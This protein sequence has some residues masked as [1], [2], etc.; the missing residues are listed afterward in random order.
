[1][2]ALEKSNT[3]M[4]CI[5]LESKLLQSKIML[6]TEE[7]NAETVTSYQTQLFY[8]RS[9]YKPEETRV[10]PIEIY[11]NS[12]GGM[13]YSTLGLYDF[14][15]KMIKEGYVIKTVNMG[16]AASGASILLMAGSP[17][18]RFSFKH[19]TTMVHQPSS[20]TYGTVTDMEI[21]CKEYLRIKEQMNEIV[22]KHASEELI[23]MMERDKWLT[24]EDA[25]KYNIIDKI[26][27]S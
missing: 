18:H 24:A 22:K 27:E 14:M 5:D 9:L 2:Y 12:P 15:Q 7:L 20:G 25:L 23:P 13:V 17:G 26:I 6:I 4:Q 21:D 19:C 11:I 1:M 16:L 3:H 8:L 10:S